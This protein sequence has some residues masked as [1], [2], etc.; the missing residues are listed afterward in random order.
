MELYNP[1]RVVVVV[2]VVVVKAAKETV[3]GLCVV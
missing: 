3:E 2:V 1:Y